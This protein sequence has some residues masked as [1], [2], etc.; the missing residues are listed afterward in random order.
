MYYEVE[1][2]T[3]F[4]KSNF[5]VSAIFLFSVSPIHF[6]L[7]F[8]RMA[9]RS[10]TD[11]KNGLCSSKPCAKSLTVLSELDLEVVFTHDSV[12]IA[13]ICHGNSVCPSVCLSVTWVDQPKSVEAR[14]TQFSPYSSPIPLVFRVS[15][16]PK[17]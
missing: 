1:L 6:C 11:G 16:I 12:A 17:F 2:E 10:V 9:Q 4:K 3:R 14:I 7:I 8:A 5:W 15:F 13:H